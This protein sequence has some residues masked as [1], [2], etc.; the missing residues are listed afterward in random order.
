MR[1][2]LREALNEAGRH[3][4]EPRR[5]AVYE[6]DNETDTERD[7]DYRKDDDFDDEDRL[8]SLFCQSCL[9]FGS[10]SEGS[11]SRLTS[12][13]RS[14]R[15]KPNSRKRKL[16]TSR[17]KPKNRMTSQDSSGSRADLNPLSRDEV[18]Q[19]E[20][21]FFPFCFTNDASS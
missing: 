4:Q 19:Y 21:V 15:S 10:F 9:R 18:Y 7:E 6:S 12:H 14:A 20:V 8:Y 11:T 5:R 16:P 1:G 13:R 3:S 17:R 2:S